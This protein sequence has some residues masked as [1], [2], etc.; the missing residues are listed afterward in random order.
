MTQNIS[1][2]QLA[3]YFSPMCPY[4]HRVLNALDGLGYSPDLDAGDANGIALRNTMAN[5][6]TATELRVGGGKST[7]PCLRIAR[8]ENGEAVEWLYESLD[9]IDFLK[10]QLAS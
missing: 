8:G 6:E 7:V 9:I 1:P 2:A 10:S 3:L 5:R 4:C